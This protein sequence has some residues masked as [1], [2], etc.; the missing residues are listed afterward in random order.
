[1]AQF[2]T[3]MSPNWQR[4]QGNRGKQDEEFLRSAQFL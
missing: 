3:K 2:S 4:I 1:V